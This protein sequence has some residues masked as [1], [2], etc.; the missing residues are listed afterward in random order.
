MKTKKSKAS[1]SA[2]QEPEKFWIHLEV[3]ISLENSDPFVRLEFV[4]DE[5]LVTEL[6][7]LDEHDGSQY[8]YPSFRTITERVRF[9]ESVAA[10][11]LANG[12]AF[13]STLG[14]DRP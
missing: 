8:I 14:Q 10:K 9:I 11:L 12:K 2:D 13:E 3:S 4:G 6:K 5:V 1:K 7:G